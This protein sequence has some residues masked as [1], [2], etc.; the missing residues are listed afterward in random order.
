VQDD[1]R[2]MIERQRNKAIK[3]ILNVNDA[4]G[5]EDARARLRSVVLAEVNGF[6]KLVLETLD[7]VDDGS[8]VNGAWLERIERRLDALHEA[9]AAGAPA[10]VPVPAGR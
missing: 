1:V 6:A 2:D 5:D 7:A 3:N 10:P 4:V 8:V 9:I